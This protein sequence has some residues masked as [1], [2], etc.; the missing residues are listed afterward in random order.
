MAARPHTCGYTHH[1]NHY[2]KYLKSIPAPGGK[3]DYQ[4]V[5][6]YY[7]GL[8]CRP[9]ACRYTHPGNQYLKSTSASEG[10]GEYQNVI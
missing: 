7:L 6:V 5:V 2:L 4:S 3:G 9:H 10:M 8:H 1:G